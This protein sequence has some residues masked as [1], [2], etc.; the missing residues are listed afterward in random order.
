MNEPTLIV[1]GMTLEA[2][3][4]L[5]EEREARL[6]A[7]L[8]AIVETPQASM[9]D[10][11]GLNKALGG[12]S[13]SCRQSLVR[14]GKIPSKMVGKRRMFVVQD[15]IDALPNDGPQH[16]SALLADV[17]DGSDLDGGD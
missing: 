8:K 17:L 11:P 12:I 4:R 13:D 15:V 7:Q 16:I 14:E 6:L 1:Q 3:E 10:G 5:L 2:F 9:T